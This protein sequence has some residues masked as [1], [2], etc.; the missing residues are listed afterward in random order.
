M[1]RRW[2][3]HLDRLLAPPHSVGSVL[4]FLVAILDGTRPQETTSSREVPAIPQEDAPKPISPV[5][6]KSQ[7]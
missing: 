1:I 5:R 7:E 3:A 6:A 4:P 2:L